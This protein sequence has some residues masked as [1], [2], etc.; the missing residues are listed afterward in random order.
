MICVMM[1]TTLRHVMLC[2]HLLPAGK[3]AQTAAHVYSARLTSQ[4]Q[5]LTNHILHYHSDLILLQTPINTKKTT[6][7][8]I[9]SSAEFL[10]SDPLEKYHYDSTPFNV[11]PIEY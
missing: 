5:I 6:H 4:L 8:S 1:M 9:I 10:K 3:L 7:I 2:H 11:K